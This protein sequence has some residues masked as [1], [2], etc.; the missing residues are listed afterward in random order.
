VKQV[1]LTK[2]EEKVLYGLIRY[3]NLSDSDLSEKINVKL[4]TL[5]SI[6][7]RLSEQKYFYKLTVPLLNRL[8][9]ELLAVIYTQF[10]P[11]IPLE[12]RVKTTRKTIEVFDEIFFSVGAQDKG[13]SISLSKNYTNIGR[14]NE[15][16][17]DT[18]GKVGLLEEKYPNEAIFPFE[19]SHIHRFFDY[20]RVIKKFFD[21]EIEDDD[22]KSKTEWFNDTKKIELTNK[23]INIYTALIEHPDAT[24]QQIGEKIGV[25]R[26]TVARMKKKFFE[27]GLL[28]QI[29]I[30]NLK[31][32]GFE[33]LA[34]YPIKFNP[35]KSPSIE[36]IDILDTSSTIFL[37]RRQ[38]ET[39][40]ISAYP[41]Y[42]DYKEDKM[43]KI[44]FLKENDFISYTP[45]IGKYM[46][47]RTIIIKDFDFAPIAKKILE[48][49]MVKT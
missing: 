48:T 21:F 46:F 31:K 28:K 20:S 36:D 4:S 6:K 15:I 30:P 41:T 24:T 33:I 40:I 3:P 44:R 39:V 45:L 43:H 26:H 8:G 35:S 49:K 10:N 27:N 25:S 7:R 19:N 13:F 42:Q 38:F 17:T 12:E 16:R 11:V 29:I 47:E 37:A 23:E 18:F 2:K 14:I 9:A 5:T 1:Q 34:F 22:T 32:L